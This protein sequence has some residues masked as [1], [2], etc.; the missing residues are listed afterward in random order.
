[1]TRIRRAVESDIEG[2]Q[3]VGRS[4]WWDTYT[5]LFPKEV[6]EQNLERW[7]SGEYLKQAVE[8]EDHIIL[9]AEEG[10]EI[11]GV[12]ETQIR[13]DN[14][15]ILWKLYVLK[16]HRGTGVGTSLIE[17]SIKQLPSQVEAYYTEYH[18]GN[19]RAAAFY[20]S[21]GFV[22]DKTEEGNSQGTPN[23]S[24]YVKQSLIRNRAISGGL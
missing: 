11:I 5:G 17:E 4:A 15:A 21:R 16:E 23:V 10:G 13:D 24:I 8:S 19:R 18:S 7:W 2:I 22:F 3:V 6:I 20:A 12:A 1:M 9:V 14:S